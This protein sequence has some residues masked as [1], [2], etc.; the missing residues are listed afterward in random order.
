VLYLWGARTDFAQNPSWR[1]RAYER[2]LM[3]R[4]WLPV[5]LFNEEIFEHYREELNSF[6][7]RA[8]FSY[9][10]PLQLFCEYLRSCGKPYHRPQT[11]IC[12]AEQLLDTQRELM[13][14]VFGCQVFNHYG[15]RETGMIASE[16][17]CHSGMHLNSRAAYLDLVPVPGGESEHLHEMLF[18]DL[19]NYGAPLIRY[20][21][22]DC[23]FPTEEECACG[24]GFPLLGRIAGRVADVFPLPNG[25]IMPVVTVM[26][27][28]IKACPGVLK[29]QFIQH[30]VDQV[31][32]LYVPSPIFRPSDLELFTAGCRTYFG[33]QVHVR[34][35]HV[36]E[37]AREPSGK[38]R[39]VISH[40]RRNAMTAATT[41]LGA[42]A[43]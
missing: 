17:A 9:C 11:I 15:S 29:M 18:T 12:T 5:S 41:V 20:R 36:S 30:K 3:R 35:T 21:I 14:S 4:V 13:E 25:D 6:R 19:L 8:I 38:T 24:S 26:G 40:V 1:W 22:N 10:T 2:Y 32:I 37:I 7:P 33:E 31:E 39:V 28:L 42:K 43:N 34:F 23:V 27:K 16:C